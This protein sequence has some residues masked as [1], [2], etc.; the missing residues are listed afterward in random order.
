MSPLPPMGPEAAQSRPGD[1]S[2][3]LPNFLHPVTGARPMAEG[4]KIC[5]PALGPPCGPGADLVMTK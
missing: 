5:R 1:P 2:G 3:E 4:T